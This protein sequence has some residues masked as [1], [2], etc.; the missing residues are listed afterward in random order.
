[1]FTVYL[2][3]AQNPIP[4]L[5]PYTL[6]HTGKGGGGRVEPER[7]VEGQQFTKL[8][9]KYHRD[10]LYL[11]SVNSDKNTCRKVPYMPMF[12]DFALL[13]IYLISPCSNVMAMTSKEKKNPYARHQGQEYGISS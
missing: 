6:I 11:Q 2:S 7:K 5:L 3:E 13:S 1:M 10:L 4:P 8:G 12:L 9:R